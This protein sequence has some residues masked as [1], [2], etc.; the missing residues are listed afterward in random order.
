MIAQKQLATTALSLVTIVFL[1]AV[2]SLAQERPE[3]GTFGLTASVQTAQLDLM[4]PIWIAPKMTVSPSLSVQRISDAVTDISLGLAVRFYSGTGR[5][6][7]FIGARGAFLILSSP[8]G[9]SAT[10]ILLGGFAGG[11]YFFDPHFSVSV[12]A[13]VNVIMN[14]ENSFR[15]GSP[16][17]TIIN[18][19]TG[20][21]ASFYF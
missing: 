12:E 13:Q 2:P 14:D 18:T 15:Y 9:H 11:E 4:F 5:A 7:P 16:D 10:D 19:G 20:I 3:A 1:A 17:K 21:F 6:A 8:G